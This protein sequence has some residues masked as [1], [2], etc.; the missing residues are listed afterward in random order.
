MKPELKR[1]EAA[2][3]EVASQYTGSPTSAQSAVTSLK[4]DGDDGEFASS[5]G[6]EAIDRSLMSDLATEIMPGLVP[7][8]CPNLPQFVLSVQQSQQVALTNAALASHLLKDLQHQVD[9]WLA[10]LRTTQQQLQAVYEEGPIVDGWLE[11][12]QPQ[13][14]QQGYRLCGLN[15][16]G[17]V[18]ERD[19]PGEQVADVSLAIARYQR[20]KTLLDQKQYLETQLGRL[21]ELLVEVHGC[22]I[23][24]G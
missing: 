14:P 1:I 10:S 23:K 15:A 19:C 13:A 18:W 12:V 24:G 11:S 4:P 3:Q 8:P 7:Q 22:P 20:W 5:F 17:Q 21:T 16:D 6:S 9:E 2:L